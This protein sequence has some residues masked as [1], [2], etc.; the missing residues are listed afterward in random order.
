[1]KVAVICLAYQREE[2]TAKTLL[3]NLPIAGIDYSLFV[4]NKKGIAHALNDGLKDAFDKAY[5][6]FC[7]L[8]NDILEPNNWLLHRVEAMT[9]KSGMISIPINEIFEQKKIGDVV[10][11][12]LI[13]RKVVETIGYFN[14]TFGEYGPIDND[15]NRRC[16]VAGFQ[17]FYLPNLKAVEIQPNTQGISDSIYG[18]SKT[19]RISQIWAIHCRDSSQYISGTKSIYFGR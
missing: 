15:Y 13:S 3:N 6:A 5:D 8:A 4:I 10:G 19:E 11:N 2:L 18:Y 12:V 17:N 7:F 1:M 16:E 14:E 9:E